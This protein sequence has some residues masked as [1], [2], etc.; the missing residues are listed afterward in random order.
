[1]SVNTVLVVSSVLVVYV[2]TMFCV[3]YIVYIHVVHVVYTYIQL[4][5]CVYS[6]VISV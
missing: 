6:Y 5:V 4:Y 3:T 1:M 2:S